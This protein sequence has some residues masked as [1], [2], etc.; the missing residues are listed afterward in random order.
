MRNGLRAALR[1]GRPAFGSWLQFGHTGVAE[2]MAQAGFEWLGID[3]EHSVIGIDS[4]QPLIQ[5]IELSG[6]AP[7]VRLPSNDPVLAKRVMDAGAHGVIVPSVNSAA[8]AERAVGAVKYPPTGFRGVGLGRAHGYGARFREYVA[9]LE[10]YAVVIVMIEQREGV[11]DLERIVRVPGVD[12]VFVGPYDLSA[13][14]G[15]AGQFEHPLMR[16]TLTRIA[17]TATSAGIAAGIHV[18]HPPVEQVW[19]RL[20][21]GFRFIAYGGDMLFLVPAVRDAA[22]QVRSERRGQAPRS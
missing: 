22:A 13:S 1:S 2:V 10:E 14:Y 4:L 18:V 8:E 7:L 3:L 20:A 21:E 11:A 16:E 6:C 15:I 17:R 19:D 12:G 5:V 9:E